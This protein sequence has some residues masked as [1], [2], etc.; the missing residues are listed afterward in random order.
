MRLSV[1]IATR[2]PWPYTKATLD[3]L[4][5]QVRA[6][7]G[8][9]IVVDGSPGGL[10][11]EPRPPFRFLR[12]LGD[13]FELRAAGIRAAEGD[14]VAVGE[15]HLRFDAS[16]ARGVL[17]QLDREPPDVAGTVGVVANG[18]LAARDRATFW[19]TLGP[20]TVA[21]ESMYRG[22]TPTPGNVAIRRAAVCDLA[23]G[24]FEYELL[25]RLLGEDRLRV[26]A[27]QRTV[28]DQSLG[29]L[30]TWKAHFASGRAFGAAPGRGNRRRR[31]REALRA[32]KLITTQTFAIQREGPAGGES[33][34]CRGCIVGIALMNSIG[35]LVGALRGPGRSGR[36]MV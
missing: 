21:R 35:Q 28:H 7:D 27:D 18:A 12:V 32:P 10:A 30:E 34:A 19:V 26:N 22:R 1:V 11:Q 15:D 23:P 24:A 14:V 4:E 31:V 9:V 36:R 2:R 16:W 6:V 20:W 5:E 29:Y 13:G 8:E 17:T 33:L 25:P 3:T